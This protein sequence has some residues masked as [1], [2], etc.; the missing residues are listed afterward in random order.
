LSY[1][2]RIPK[3]L[4][5][6]GTANGISIEHKNH[7]RCIGTDRNHNTYRSLPSVIHDLKSR[8][9]AALHSVYPFLVFRHSLPAWFRLHGHTMTGNELEFLKSKFCIFFYIH[10]D[11]PTNRIEAHYACSYRFWST[12]ISSKFKKSAAVLSVYQIISDV[13]ET[14]FLNRFVADATLAVI[15]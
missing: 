1:S 2:G 8:I 11:R 10:M 9:D 4:V 7:D 3:E 15:E 13:H 6:K 14:W 12:L 5:H